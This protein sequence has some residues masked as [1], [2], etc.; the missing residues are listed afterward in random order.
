VL[1]QIRET[2]GFFLVKPEI[3]EI[4]GDFGKRHIRGRSVVTP[5]LSKRRRIRGIFDG[6]LFRHEDNLMHFV[7]NFVSKMDKYTETNIELSNK[8]YRAV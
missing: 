3:P 6:R 2:S 7:I 8:L 1:T 5:I 4:R